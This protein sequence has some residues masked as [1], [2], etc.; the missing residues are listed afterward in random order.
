MRKFIAHV[1][2]LALWFGLVW[3]VVYLAKNNAQASEIKQASC[4]IHHDQQI[5]VMPCRIVGEYLAVVQL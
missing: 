1:L 5:H 3:M 4:E 2:A